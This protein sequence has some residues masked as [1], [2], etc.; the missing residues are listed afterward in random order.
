MTVYV[1]MPSFRRLKPDI[2]EQLKAAEEALKPVQ[3][4]FEE[5]RNTGGNVAEDRE[6]TRAELQEVLVSVLYYK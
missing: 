1:S 5:L 4:R 6:T 3:L 2:E